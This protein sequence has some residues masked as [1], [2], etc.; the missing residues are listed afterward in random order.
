MTDSA[1][2]KGGTRPPPFRDG[3]PGWLLGACLAA[4]IGLPVLLGADL[5]QVML[6]IIALTV[7]AYIV[8]CVAG[9][10][11]SLRRGMSQRTRR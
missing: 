2:D 1:T 7:A 3:L 6:G 11:Q 8:I 9:M 10:V 4:A 5:F